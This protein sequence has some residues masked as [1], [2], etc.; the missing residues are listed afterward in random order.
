MDAHSIP[1]PSR[2][3]TQNKKRV[4]IKM[5]KKVP[6]LTKHRHKRKVSTSKKPRG[7]KMRAMKRKK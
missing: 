7:K 6:K 3:G 1:Y 5:A 4:K 2:S